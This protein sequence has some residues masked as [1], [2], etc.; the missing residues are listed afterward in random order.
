M[1]DIEELYLAPETVNNV[2]EVVIDHSEETEA[3]QADKHIIPA[4]GKTVKTRVNEIQELRGANRKVFR[5]SDGTEQ[6]VFYPTSVHVYDDETH[7]FKEVENTLVEEE[8]GR[9]FVCG[10]NNFVAKFSREEE[11][12][13]LF[14]VESGMHR[15]TVSAKKVRKQKNKGVVPK[16]GKRKAEET[17]NTELLTFEEVESGADYEYSLDTAGIKENIVIKEKSNLYRY[18]FILKCENVTARFDEDEKRIAF[19][20]DETGEEVFFIPAPFMIDADGNISDAVFYEMKTT[21]N[22]DINL[23][24]TAD[25]EWINAE[26]RAMP[27]VIDPQIKLSGSSNLR[28]FSWD[29]GYMSEPS[30]HTI[31]ISNNCGSRTEKQMYLKLTKPVL[32]C[33]PRIKKAELELTVY[34]GYNNSGSI[35]KLGLYNVT[36]NIT[37]GYCSPQ[38]DE[39]ILDYAGIGTSVKAY[40]KVVFDVTNLLD[41]LYSGETSTANLML[42]LMD[43]ITTV[44]ITFYGDNYSSYAPKLT[45]TYESN[46]GVNGSYRSNTHRLGRFGL[47]SIDLIS[48]NLM[49]ESEDFAWSGNR[50]PVTIKHLYNS[51]LSDHKYTKNSAIRLN[52]ADYSSMSIGLGWKLNIMQSMIYDSQTDR[53]VF[54]DENGNET[55]FKLSNKT[56][57]C[58]SNSQCYKLY[59]DEDG[60]EM[61]YDDQNRALTVGDTKYFFDGGGKLVKVTEGNNTMHINYTSGKITSVTDGAGRDFGLCYDANGY[62][63]SIT[64][65]DYSSQ[66]QNAVLYSY[67]DGLLTEV[68]YPDGRSA[69]IEYTDNKPK[70][71]I[72]KNTDGNPV[73]KVEYTFNGNRVASVTEFGFE[74]G[75]YITGVSSSYTYSAA[76][77]RTLVTTIEPKDSSLGETEDKTVT[78]V[79]SFDDNG[80]VIGEYAY[81]TDGEKNGVSGGSGINPYSSGMNAVSNVD[82]LLL[83]HSFTDLENWASESANAGN[84]NILNYAY[85]PYAKFGK[86]VLR[87]QSYNS[88]SAG[89]GVYQNTVTLPAGEYTLSAY[90]RIVSAYSGNDNPGAFIRVT[91]TDGTVIAESEH[92]KKYNSEYVRIIAPFKLETAQ[93][94]CVHLIVNGAG[95]SYFDGIQLEKNAYANSYNMLINSNFERELNGWSKS[96]NALLSDNESFNMTHSLMLTGNPDE[97][98]NAVQTV[99]VKSNKGTR[100]TFTLSGWAKGFA[101]PNNERENCEAAEFSLSAEIKYSDSTTETHTAALSPCTNEWQLAQVQFAKQEY[102]QVEE[103]K[104]YCNYNHNI[105]TAFFDD[106]RLFRNSLETGLSEADFASD[107]ADMDSVTEEDTADKFKEVTDYYGNTLTETTFADGEFGTVYRSY[108]YT[109]NCNC[110]E[111]AGNDLISETDSRGNKIKYTVDADTSRNEVITDRCGNKTVYAYDINGRITGVVNK[112]SDGTELSSVSYGYDGFNNLTE[113]TRGDGMKYAISYNAFHNLEAIGINGMVDKNNN[114][115]KLIK[116]GYKNG[117]GRLKEMIYANGNIMRA[118]Y[119][120]YGQLIAEKWYSAATDAE[121]EAHYRYVYDNL[122]NIVRSID[123]KE[124]K[125]YNY[126]YEEGRIVRAAEYGITLDGSLNV[127]AKS[128]ISS[129][130]YAYNS[131]GLLSKKTVVVGDTQAVYYTEYPENASPVI[132]L[133]VNGKTA[134]CHSKADSFGRKVFDELRLGT[135]FVSRQ[136]SYHAGKA[137]EEHKKNGKL[138]S[139]PTTNLVSQ[140]VLSDGGTLSYAYDAEER[141]TSVIE[142]YVIDEATVTNTTAYTYDEMGRLLTETV[143]GTAVNTM[144]YD[145]YGNI[146]TK[147]GVSYEYDSVW[148]DRLKQVGTELTV[149]YD[150]QGNPINYLGHTLNWE[151]GRQLKSFDNNTYAYNANGIRTSKTVNGIKHSFALDGSKILREEWC[152]NTL[153]PLYDNADSVCGIMYNGQHYFFL[154]N[155][156]G[157]VIAI[158][159]SNGD[160]V[161]RYSYDAWGA[162]TVTQ[163]S[164][165]RSIA[166]VNPY[167]YRG[168]YFDSET[169][170]YY[171]QS[172][173]YDP[174]VGRFINADAPDYV[175]IQGGNLFAYCGNCPTKNADYA[176]FCYTPTYPEASVNGNSN[177]SFNL[178]NYTDKSWVAKLF[179]KLGF[180]GSLGKPDT[181]NLIDSKAIR[182]YLQLKADYTKNIGSF[183]TVSNNEI[184]FNSGNTS[185]SFSNKVLFTVSL[186]LFSSSIKASIGL[187]SKTLFLELAICQNVSSG[188]NKVSFAIKFVMEVD[189]WLIALVTVT[190]AALSLIPVFSPVAGPITT[191]IGSLVSQPEI[192]LPAFS[193]SMVTVLYAIP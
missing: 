163:D 115:V 166:T 97:K 69:S 142:T 21:A 186:P 102:K 39:T 141:I 135:G 48:G 168:Y 83:N 65:P 105:G 44:G 162:C 170:L 139:S 81:S 133:T 51:A 177:S 70:T 22:G 5:M 23:T 42:K 172:R 175:A 34:S 191:M 119:N 145:S 150:D 101:L 151:K 190:V 6:A 96:G 95:T 121:P 128:L 9:H 165:N 18:P 114:P 160:T 167:R 171:L 1:G 52:T 136:F 110:A 180:K 111:N 72:L 87:L 179:K 156:Q 137:T 158:T 37:T 169:E 75:V 187:N 29:N 178:N 49:L 50:M 181:I 147:N 10:K 107:E 192:T 143:N 164:S 36:G 185:L 176:G 26:G 182:I 159:D 58:C 106:I 71:I 123:I 64:A 144:T 112:S 47:G 100:E 116:Y 132:K 62:L 24:V 74:N 84:F 41:K 35:K 61:Y 53:Y 193:T 30:T 152:G 109:S 134:E 11:N 161:A 66:N 2:E 32:P 184:S 99:A 86:K 90:T 67:S 174:S 12:D 173:Y 125:E 38:Y 140:I 93:N 153:I 27:I 19:L 73:Y 59:E 31:N 77:N 148:K 122:G 46:Y 124:E 88:T 63:T 8:D 20:N 94:V 17:E 126:T 68:T 127:T 85:E 56:T 149:E 33:N 157:D 89:N 4:T 14:S 15:I 3:A 76:A 138:K 103:L 57:N 25:S 28:S 54:T 154:K 183:M 120:G 91:K 79:Y 7:S 40:S 118:T 60:S 82:N 189:L 78:T 16:R 92:I 146:L 155:L 117:N 188:K 131:K 13:E 129:I 80:T 98:C 55:Y 45:V 130:E 43:E 104:I 113:I 108:E